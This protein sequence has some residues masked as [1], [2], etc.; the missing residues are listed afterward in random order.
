MEFT[1]HASHAQFCD[2]SKRECQ[3][4]KVKSGSGRVIDNER[5]SL[6]EVC[7]KVRW[8]QTNNASD[9]QCESERESARRTH[10]ISACVTEIRIS[11]TKRERGLHRQKVNN[12]KGAFANCAYVRIK[13]QIPSHALT[14]GTRDSVNHDV[15]TDCDDASCAQCVCVFVWV[16][17]LIRCVSLGRIVKLVGAY[18]SSAVNWMTHNDN[19]IRATYGNHTISLHACAT[20]TTLVSLCSIALQVTMQ[21][22]IIQN[23]AKCVTKSI[24]AQWA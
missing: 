21:M 17:T 9:Q 7:E 3:T 19:T 16:S 11:K 2:E 18:V 13:T 8:L 6:A 24:Y 15:V 12:R 5:E 20:Q 1:T 22:K 14:E 23:A 10:I 4:T